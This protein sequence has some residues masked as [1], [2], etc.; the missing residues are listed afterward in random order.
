MQNKKW[1]IHGVE[2]KHCLDVD[3]SNEN[4]ARLIVN[5]CDATNLKMKWTFGN[6]NETTLN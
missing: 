4:S 3:D 6:L 1:I 5:V 2:Q